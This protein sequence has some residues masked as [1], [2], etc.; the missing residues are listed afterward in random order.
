MGNLNWNGPR[1][2]ADQVRADPH[3]SH[4]VTPWPGPDDFGYVAEDEAGTWIGVVWLKHFSSRAP[5]YGFIDEAIPELGIHVIAPQ[6]GKGAGARLLAA[7]VDEARRRQLPGISLSVE[8]A[9][10]ARRLYA[11]HGFVPAGPD[12]DPGTLLL[13]FSAEGDRPSA[14]FNPVPT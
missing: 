12:Y 10:P 11:R 5:G 6:R 4:Y 7:A 9:N 2:T 3:L 8:S 1:F 13:N 14:G